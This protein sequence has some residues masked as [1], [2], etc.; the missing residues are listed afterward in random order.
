MRN[1]TPD[2]LADCASKLKIASLNVRGLKHRLKFPEFID[3]I[4]SYDIICITETHLDNTDIIDV[5]NYTFIAKNRTQTYLRKSGEIGV[6]VKNDIL[7]G[8]ETKKSNSEYVLW[9]KISKILTNTDDD[10]M[11]GVLYVPPEKI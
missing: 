1:A 5:P 3:F 4:Y 7:H 8:T 6:F 11:L 10:I 2:I 9:L